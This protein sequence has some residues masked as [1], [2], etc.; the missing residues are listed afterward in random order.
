MRFA[1]YIAGLL[2]LAVSAFAATLEKL[3]LDQMAQQATVIVRGRITGCATEMRGPVIYTRCAVAVTETWKGSA[4]QK[5][6]FVVPGGTFQGLSQTFSGSPKFNADEQFVL[7][8]WVGRSGIPQIIGL[9]QGVFSVTT[10][11]KG[12]IT[13]KKEAS[14][15]VM[16]DARGNQV[17]D[18]AISM[19]VGELRSRVRQALGA[20]R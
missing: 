15:E 11:D 16:L 2:V 20:A 8:L 9:S 17:R 19:G 18:E 4:A 1:V 6:D 13:V 5:V 10:S 12:Q 14:S 3:T 7:F